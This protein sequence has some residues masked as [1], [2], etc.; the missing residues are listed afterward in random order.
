MVL[1]NGKET[2]DQLF[3]IA[4]KNYFDNILNNSLEEKIK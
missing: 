3:D 2:S 1:A 4:R